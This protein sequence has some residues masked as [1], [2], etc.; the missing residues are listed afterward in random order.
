MPQDTKLGLDGKGF[1]M[2]LVV[3]PPAPEAT[4]ATPASLPAV[5]PENVSAEYMAAVAVSMQKQKELE[6]AEH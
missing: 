3:K 6:E 5:A 1:N 4:A 2:T